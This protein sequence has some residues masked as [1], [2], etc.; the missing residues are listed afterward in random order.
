MTNNYFVHDSAIISSDSIIG[1]NSKIWHFSHIF[2]SSKIGEKCNIGQNVMIGPNVL[3]GNR[4]KIQNNVSVYKGITIEDDVF[5]GPSCVFTNVKT[6]RAFIDRSEEFSTT[7]I[8]KGVSIGA[9]STI[10]C[11]VTIGE[12]SMIAA[13]SIVTKDVL[14]FSL[15]LGQPA[16]HVGWIS[17]SGDRLGKDLVCKRTG[18]KY[19]LVNGNLY[20]LNELDSDA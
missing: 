19:E 2:G 1:K 18:D 3:I 8:K 20:E 17:K 6:P 10:V 16:K 12:Y 5:C 4:C 14:P 9:N 15:V 7:L 13:G 11:G